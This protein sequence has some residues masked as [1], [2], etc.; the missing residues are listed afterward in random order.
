M[1]IQ[2]CSAYI[3]AKK[4]QDKEGLYRQGII[5]YGWSNLTFIFGAIVFWPFPMSII[6]ELNIKS[7]WLWPNDTFYAEGQIGLQN[8]FWLYKVAVHWTW[9]EEYLNNIQFQTLTSTHSVLYSMVERTY[10]R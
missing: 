10:K 5:R 3:T 2:Y 1:D 6:K 4:A 9:L 8:V 7:N